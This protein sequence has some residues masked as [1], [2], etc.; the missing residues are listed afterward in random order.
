M[1]GKVTS[2]IVFTA[3]SLLTTFQSCESNSEEALY[4][5][6]PCD[7]TNVTWNSG[8]EALLAK[9]CVSC[10]GPE[11][12]Y[13]GVRHDSYQSEL[14]VVNDGRLRGVVNQLSGFAKMPKDMGK[15]PDCEILL[16]N[17]WLDNGAPEN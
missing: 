11:I 13:N 2:F 9:R 12:A 4:G 16:I 1:A 7:V 17:T 3:F 14:I 8:I 15:L 6:Q 10:H 5:I